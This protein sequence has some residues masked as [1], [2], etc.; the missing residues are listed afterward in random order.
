MENVLN[1]IDK[2]AMKE[3]G[4]KC[5]AQLCLKKRKGGRERWEEKGIFSALNIA[6]NKKAHK[7]SI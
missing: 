1:K 3:V 7:S 2:T 6:E 4:I 5:Y